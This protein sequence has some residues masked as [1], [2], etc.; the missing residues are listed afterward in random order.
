MEYKS[1][2]NPHQDSDSTAM[3]RIFFMFEHGCQHDVA[4]EE[5]E[6]E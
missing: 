3:D 5:D 2:H 6:S 4:D 1:C